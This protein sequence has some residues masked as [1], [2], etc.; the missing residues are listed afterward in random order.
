[1]PIDTLK[2]CLQVYGDRGLNIVKDRVTNE[3]IKSLY[4][5]SIASC[6]ATIVGHYPWFLTY[7]TLSASLPT[8]SELSSL[9]DGYALNQGTN[10]FMLCCTARAFN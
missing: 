10:L 1:M 8:A 6:G 9:A 5:G 4:L 7:N 2:T 3:G